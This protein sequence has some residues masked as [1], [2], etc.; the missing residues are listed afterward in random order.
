[1]TYQVGSS[2]GETDLLAKIH[3]FAVTAGWTSNKNTSTYINLSK[4]NLYQNI[5]IDGSGTF[6]MKAAEGFDTGLAW[7]AQ[8]T[9]SYLE[10][11]SLYLT[12]SYTKYHLFTNSTG[13]YI[14]IVVE[15]DPG[16]F[17]H[18]GFG[19]LDKTSSYA[20]GEYSVSV[21]HEN[22]RTLDAAQSSVLFM[23]AG[24]AAYL[25]AV[26]GST[27]RAVYD[28]ATSHWLALQVFPHS[29][30]E[31]EGQ[32]TDSPQANNNLS[33][34]F[35]DWYKYGITTYNQLTPLAPI[36]LFA[37]R[38]ANL[39]SPLGV[40][41]DLRTLTIENFNPSQEVTI[42]SDTWIVFPKT[43]KSSALGFDNSENYAYA[44]KK[45]V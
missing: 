21:Y 14:H 4:G 27:I 31:Q 30:V 13:D 39:S 12:G 24:N 8:P 35:E 11:I 37:G 15:V 36:V 19:L 3:T 26:R 7:N 38:A 32:G 41:K 29:S 6:Y 28:G 10:Q 43:R 2:T 44:Y 17:K 42:G 5:F 45:I 9:Q 23:G 22:T 25:G 40:V 16:Y 18:F 34:L 1:M 33:K 20:G